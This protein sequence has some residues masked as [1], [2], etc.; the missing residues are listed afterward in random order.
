LLGGVAVL[1]LVWSSRK[2]HNRV[3]PKSRIWMV[4]SALKWLFP[5]AAARFGFPL[6]MCYIFIGAG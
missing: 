5:S 1:E 4:K 2:T 3:K 6:G